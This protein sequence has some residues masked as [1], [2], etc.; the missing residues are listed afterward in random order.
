GK[1]KSNCCLLSPPM[2]WAKF[3]LMLLNRGEANGNQ[4]VQAEFIDQMTS[5]AP[6]SDWYGLQIWLTDSNDSNPWLGLT[7]GYQKAEDFLREDA[8]YASGFG[9]QRVYVVPSEELVIVR[10]GPATGEDLGS[11]VRADWDN[12]FLVN[13]AIR[14]LK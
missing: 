2:N 4:I 14:H 9:A 5:P 13:T 3:G 1:A 11:P 7:R 10:M 12:A 8:Y 6:N